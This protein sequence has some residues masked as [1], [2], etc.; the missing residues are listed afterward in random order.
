MADKCVIAVC[1]ATGSQGGALVRAILSDKE[2]KFRVRAITRDANSPKA[3]ELAKLGV[4]LVQANLDDVESL[5]KAFAGVYGVYGVTNFWE[6]MNVEHELEQ[7]KNLAQAAKAAKVKHFIW[8]TLDDTRLLVPLDD[9]RMPTL[10]GKYKVPHFDGKGEGNQ[11]FTDMGVP[12]TFFNTTFYWEDFIGFGME[13]KRRDGKLTL[14]LPMDNQRLA[15]IAIKD[16]GLCA[17]EIL[18][19]GKEFIGKTVNIAGEHLTGQEMAAQMSKALGEEVVYQSITPAEYRDLGFQGAQEFGNM[20]Q[21]YRD[22]SDHYCGARDIEEIRKLNPQLQNFSSWLTE[23][24]DR[25]PIE[26]K[27]ERKLQVG[28]A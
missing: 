11:I 2:G 19:R 26:R 21:Y 23:N 10:M 22:F 3:K 17:Y 8:S 18:K 16:I 13:P 25:I 9:D 15:G 7:V 4:E 28:S 1:G 14:T 6:Y 27:S 20:F 24:G 5:K 12:T